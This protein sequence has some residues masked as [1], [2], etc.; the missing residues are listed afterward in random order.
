MSIFQSE[1]L[2]LKQN[3]ETQFNEQQIEHETQLN[4]ERVE[5]DEHIQV[6]DVL[7]VLSLQKKTP[8]RIS[9]K[10]SVQKRIQS[11]N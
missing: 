8:S 11:M 7:S 10:F 6:R 3:S 2:Q 4:R 1:I 9:R 5:H